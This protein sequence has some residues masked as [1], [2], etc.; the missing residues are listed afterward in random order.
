MMAGRRI[1][2]QNRTFDPKW[3]FLAPFSSVFGIFAGCPVDDDGF[4]VFLLVAK[5]TIKER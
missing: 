1:L 5:L 2:A 3:S 4:P